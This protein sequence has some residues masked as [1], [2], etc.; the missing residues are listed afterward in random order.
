[1]PT[2]PVAC[3]QHTL[4]RMRNV[5]NL[6]NA[7]HPEKYMRRSVLVPRTRPVV[8]HAAAKNGPAS[9]W[10]KKL[11]RPQL[12]FLEGV[13][14]VEQGV[15]GGVHRGE[16]ANREDEEDAEA[17]RAPEDDLEHF[18]FHCEVTE[19]GAGG[20]GKERHGDAEVE[21][22]NGMWAGCCRTGEVENEY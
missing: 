22:R 10:G 16:G 17:E 8:R 19:S 9:P 1:M 11:E 4:Y 12:E 18:G 14:C 6:V 7:T 20:E 21:G 5:N 3:T 13:V 15:G 2:R